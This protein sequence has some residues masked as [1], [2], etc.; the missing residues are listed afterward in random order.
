MIRS[1]LLGFLILATA[2][3][4][5][6][7]ATPSAE[8]AEKSHETIKLTAGSP[9]LGYLKIEPVA[10]AG[11][12]PAM[13]LTGKVSFDENHTQRVSS[14]VDGRAI[15]MLV[16]L[17]DK[18]KVGQS[19]VELSS[20]NVGQLQAD[21]QKAQQDLFLSEKALVRV[22][23]LK[24]DGAV[25]E[26][27]V[28]QVESDN[29]KAHADV[30]SASSKLRSLNLAA[31]DPGASVALRAQVAGTVV[32]RSVLVGQEVR[33]DGAVPLITI[34]DLGVVWV[35]GDVYEQDIP[36][37]QQGTT[38]TVS[39]T[40][41][42]GVEFPGTVTHLSEVVDPTSRTVKLRCVVP[43]PE[44]KLKPEMF[45]KILLNDNGGKK[46]VIPSRS[47]LSETQPPRVVVVEEDGTFRLHKVEVGPEVAGRVR[48]LSGLKA[49]DKIVTDGAIFLKQEI[50][51]Q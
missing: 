12:A 18:V 17:G 20:P 3:C 38:V 7:D 9:H 45:V 28:A 13:V 46:L 49:G 29:R 11:D 23:K 4:S 42:P 6:H 32:D 43:N 25:S 47:V 51:N 22:H 50:E 39:V 10:V 31:G 8:A 24:E 48:V 37:V 19:L 41:Y 16:E 35:A 36:L 40:A 21:M 14:P 30:A 34:S 2:A 44:G 5:A 33:A 27:D 1:S 15:K 26:K